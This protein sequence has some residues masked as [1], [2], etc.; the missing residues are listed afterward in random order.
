M[1][2]KAI[3]TE[4]LEASKLTD[5]YSNLTAKKLIKQLVFSKFISKI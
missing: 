3:L 2:D 1:G 4:V 5:S